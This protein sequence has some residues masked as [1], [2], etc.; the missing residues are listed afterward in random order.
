MKFSCQHCGQHIAADP[1]MAGMG[2]T[3]PTCGKGLTIPKPG[4][5]EDLDAGPRLASVAKRPSLWPWLGGASLLGVMG[6]IIW[7]AYVGKDRGGDRP[8]GPEESKPI[9]PEARLRYGTDSLVVER[10]SIRPP[11][12]TPRSTSMN[13]PA[14][15]DSLPPT[16]MGLN[17]RKPDKPSLPADFRFTALTRIRSQ[18][19]LPYILGG[20]SQF[21]FRF[22]NTSPNTQVWLFDAR[23]AVTG[24]RG[25][26]LSV[27]RVPGNNATASGRLPVLEGKTDGVSNSPE[28]MWTPESIACYRDNDLLGIYEPS[29]NLFRPANS[30]EAPQ[31]LTLPPSSPV[32]TSPS[33]RSTRPR[34]ST[35]PR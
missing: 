33:T 25:R 19:K 30:Y 26:G 11:A 12:M 5:A 22:R 27:E 1:T 35:T 6:I 28:Y 32:T 13:P 34:F 14:S 3:C 20:S 23:D 2:V 7:I 10:K 31:R 4:G 24:L 16:R 18:V 29:R 21:S 15:G 9:P 8:T 17:D